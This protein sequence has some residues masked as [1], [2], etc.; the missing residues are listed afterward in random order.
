MPMGKLRLIETRLRHFQ[1]HEDAHWTFKVGEESAGLIGV[2]GSNG[3]G[4]STILDSQRFLLIGEVPDYNKDE[5]VG[6]GAPPGEPAYVKSLYT[7][8]GRP[9][10]MHRELTGSAAWYKFDGGKPVKGIT[11]FNEFVRDTMGLDKEVCDKSIFIRQ[12]DIVDILFTEPAK[13]RKAWLRL[14]GMGEAEWIHATMGTYMGGLLP[15]ADHSEEVA[16]HRLRVKALRAEMHRIWKSVPAPVPDAEFAIL[17]EKI[18]NLHNRQGAVRSLR[19]AMEAARARHS[20]AA[21][22]VQAKADAATMADKAMALA[23][24]AKLNTPSPPSDAEQRL[25]NMQKNIEDMQASVNAYRE[26]ESVADS[27][28]RTIARMEPAKAEIS[29]YTEKGLQERQNV[30]MD[31]RDKASKAR[32]DEALLKSLH[33]S[34]TTGHRGD[35][36]T[37]P[38][39]LQTIKNKAALVGSLEYRLETA[40]QLAQKLSTEADT[41]SGEVT[42]T[43]VL[44][45]NAE[46]EYTVVSEQIRSLD[47]R[48]DQL[49][50]KI[51]GATDQKEVDDLRTGMETIRAAIRMAGELATNEKIAV[52]AYEAASAAYNDAVNAEKLTKEEADRAAQ[53]LVGSDTQET[54][55]TAR[56]PLEEALAARNDARTRRQ[57]LLGE[58]A[59]TRASVKSVISDI[60][61]LEASMAREKA[62]RQAVQVLE[63]V[64]GFFHHTQGPT[65]VVARVLEDITGGVNEF[66][67]YFNAPFTV[68]PDLAEM[69]FR[70]IWI[71]GRQAPE[72]PPLAKVLSGGQ[73]VALAL[74]FRLAAY[75]MFSSRL[76]F[77][78]LDEPTNHL[79]EDNVANFGHLMDKLRNLARETTLQILISTH[80]RSIVSSLD[81]VI[82][83]GTGKLK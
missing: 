62:Q 41:V 74:S 40:R 73:K 30:Y 7:F 54:I 10:E 13:R 60:R 6:W 39:C 36:T 70:I 8:D 46:R 69:T 5:L 18:T 76:G 44:K 57:G 82:D 24:S 21:T 11:A 79:D 61:R 32:A 38:L 35:L 71:D 16:T 33:T 45:S 17:N 12:N 3:S 2:I 20:M 75:F 47:L 81:Y 50:P 37:C 80:A 9:L 77:M 22:Q 68:M 56:R 27:L 59:G 14:M 52:A 1:R 29:K 25:A 31:L 23:I 72:T 51:T 83:L 65:M 58:L 15:M 28:E 55:D 26:L 48:K 42:R 67:G 64:R 63:D 78:T 49:V 43:R 19:T 34:L 4:K 53:A 66:L